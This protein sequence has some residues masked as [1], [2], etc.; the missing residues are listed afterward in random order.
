MN[1]RER[2][3]L[4]LLVLTFGGWQGWKLLD[5]SLF[6]P[7]RRRDQEIAALQ[8]SIG[9]KQLQQRRIDNLNDQLNEWKTQSLPPIRSSP[10]PFIR[11]GS[12]IWPPSPS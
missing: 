11:C 2:T 5:A 7:V 6:E 1:S 3:L 12:S 4:I 9:D 8:D 10:L